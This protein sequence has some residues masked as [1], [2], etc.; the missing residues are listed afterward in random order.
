MKRIILGT[1]GHI[2]HGKTAL[3]KALTG[4]DTDR[5]KEEKERG[6]TIDLGF[7]HLDLDENISIGIVDVPG[8]ERFVKN[9]LAGVGGID[10]VA[11]IIAADEGVMP[12]TREHV[13]ICKLLEIKSGLVV[14]TKTDLVEED[15]LA[16]VEEDVKEFL[17]GTFL[18]GCPLV[19]TSA[20]T[21][22]GL[23]EFLTQL[24]RIAREVET[25]NVSGPF[26][27]PIDRVFTMKGFGTVVTGTLTSGSVKV[28]D[29]VE[30]FPRNIIARI[31]NIQIHNQSAVEA[32]AG[33]RTAFNLSGVEKSFIERGDVLSIPGRLYPTTLIDSKMSLLGS[34]PHPIKQRARVRFH[35]GTAEVM[36]RVILLDRDRL[37][38]GGQAYVQLMLEKPLSALPGDRFVIR[39]YSPIITIGGGR[40]LEVKTTRY[41][42]NRKEVLDHL[43]VLETGTHHEVV[44][45]MLLKA[46]V[47]GLSLEELY[48]RFD[49][50]LDQIR[51]HIK[52]LI[53]KG[54]AI[55]IDKEKMQATHR[56]PFEA[57]A[58][59]AEEQLSSFHREN[60]LKR[61][62]SREE[63]RSKIAPSADK[64]FT[65]CME[66]LQKKGKLVVEKD[67]VRLS[68]HKVKLQEEQTEFKRR[69][70][71]EFR[72]S[73]FQPP[74]PHEA[75]S[76]LS[77]PEQDGKEM[78]QLLIN[79]GAVTR[80]KDK[81]IYH[82]NNLSKAEE[83]LAAFLKEKGEITAAQFRDLL[84][85]SR[86][87]AIPL[88]EH[89]DSK[90][91]TFRKGDV[92][93]LRS[94]N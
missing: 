38:Q 23:Q 78:L 29:Q 45:A 49:L 21:G 92:R 88:L 9:M 44:E 41:R 87:Y 64:T 40:I 63:L 17:K 50:P 85:I 67:L 66:Y 84:D 28:E 4:I 8:H 77:I 57:M 36:A 19:F 27:M 69:L 46:G 79:E 15:W 86:K 59:R 14:I 48:P 76:R 32:A 25:R 16:L 7:A 22:Q 51:R 20:K 47:A 39:S 53:D 30:V 34:A 1:A 89:F 5:L 12:Q 90:K 37:E 70:E 56:L 6:I 33:Q 2:D 52:D 94:R 91:V 3:I 58:R 26:R 75:F 55:L 81:V 68:T 93:V 82:S 74:S 54:C 10:L 72:S 71:E 60:P 62:M 61:G 80:I 73:G 35:H 18:D 31:R 65:R 83:M 13:A 11:L 42:R 24:S 43:K